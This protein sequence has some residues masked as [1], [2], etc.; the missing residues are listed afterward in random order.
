MPL[1]FAPPFSL[2]LCSKLWTLSFQDEK[3]D[4]WLCLG[5]SR[6]PVAWKLSPGNEQGHL[7]L[8]SLVLISQDQCLELPFV[9]HF[10]YFVQFSRWLGRR[11]NTIPIFQLWPETEFV[12]T[13]DIDLF[14]PTG[15]SKIPRIGFDILAMF[16]SVLEY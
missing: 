8:T 14:N 15:F 16:L 2:V 13:S 12:T 11:T 10:I 5:S 9:Q 7:W 1:F 3:D 6:H 4:C